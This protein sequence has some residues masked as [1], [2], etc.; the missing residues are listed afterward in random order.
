ME[1]INA[2]QAA[3]GQ[4][5]HAAPGHLFVNSHMYHGMSVARGGYYFE[6]TAMSNV[7]ISRVRIRFTS[8]KLSEDEKQEIIDQ[9][10]KFYKE[11]NQAYVNDYVWIID[12]IGFVF[13][14][15][16]HCVLPAVNKLNLD[17]GKMTASVAFDPATKNA[18]LMVRMCRTTLHDTGHIKVLKI[19]TISCGG[20]AVDVN[21][22]SLDSVRRLDIECNNLL[23]K[24]NL[25][26]GLVKFPALIG[27]RLTF[28]KNGGYTPEDY[29][30]DA[31][32]AH[33]RKILDGVT[34]FLGS[35][36]EH[37]NLEIL[38]FRSFD[39]EYLPPFKNSLRY[40]EIAGCSIN[41]ISEFLDTCEATL[42]M[43]KIRRINMY[44][45]F[46]LNTFDLRNMLALKCLQIKMCTVSI[47]AFPESLKRIKIHSLSRLVI[48]NVSVYDNVERITVYGN[49]K[50][51]LVCDVP[52]HQIFPN[53]VITRMMSD[54]DDDDE[55]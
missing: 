40:L 12:G 1:I 48:T 47:N 3:N 38:E 27:L 37:P 17:F 34:A 28:D 26:S 9:E 51:N 35:V 50:L 41:S 16:E 5:I 42:V 44:G 25:M 8:N 15:T 54:G 11:R 29:E 43:L 36:G 20:Q 7:L 52:L 33:L 21:V 14:M 53:A 18:E 22:D 6:S 46:H 10:V 19:T 13:P 55:D 31:D 39:I 49:A 24:G 30:P 32:K 23:M 2:D 4:V 45:G